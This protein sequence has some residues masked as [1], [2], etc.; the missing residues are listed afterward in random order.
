MTILVSFGAYGGFYVRFGY[1]WR[2]CFGWVAVTVLP[3]DIDKWWPDLLERA[4]RNARPE[5]G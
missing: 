4:L 1:T 2:I 3:F 5:K